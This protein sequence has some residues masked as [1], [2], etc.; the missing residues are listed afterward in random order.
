MKHFNG[1]ETH[2]KTFREHVEA[3]DFH[4]KLPQGKHEGQN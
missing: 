4:F 2:L 3:M 1:H